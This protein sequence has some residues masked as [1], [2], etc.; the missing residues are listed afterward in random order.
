MPQKYFINQAFKLYLQV[1]LNVNFN[2]T[3]RMGISLAEAI[4]VETVLAGP[5]GL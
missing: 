5:F 4:K 3:K 2:Y 1:V